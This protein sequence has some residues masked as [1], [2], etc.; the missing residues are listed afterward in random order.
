MSLYTYVTVAVWHDSTQLFNLATKFK[1]ECSVEWTQAFMERDCRDISIRADGSTVAVMRRFI[2][3]LTMLHGI[4]VRAPR[5]NKLASS[6]FRHIPELNCS[7]T[8]HWRLS[9]NWT[10]CPP[11]LSLPLKGL[12]AVFFGSLNI[13]LCPT[14][15]EF[16]L[17]STIEHPKR[18]RAIL[19]IPQ[20]Y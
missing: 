9:I 10:D 13:P 19:P 16:G 17:S 18:Q 7:S 14:R 5:R 11:L 1:L 20:N 3:F 6:G 2:L 8:G 12:A 15:G 4:Q